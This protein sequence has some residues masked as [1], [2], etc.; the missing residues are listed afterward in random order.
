MC[1]WQLLSM[2]CSLPVNSVTYVSCG[3]TWNLGKSWHMTLTH[4]AG[5]VHVGVIIVE[6]VHPCLLHFP[7]MLDRMVFGVVI[8][9]VC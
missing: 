4:F 8:S 1:D 2:M 6:H 7:V 3:Y 5:E 9:K